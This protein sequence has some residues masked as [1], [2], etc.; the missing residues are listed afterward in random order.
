MQPT[1]HNHT[2][3]LGFPPRFYLVSGW[4]N[5]APLVFEEYAHALPV[6]VEAVLEALD[7][8]DDGPD[9][10]LLIDTGAG[11]VTD[12]T[13]DIAEA[14]ISRDEWE[15]KPAPDWAYEAIGACPEVAARDIRA[16]N[17]AWDAQ[18]DAVARGVYTR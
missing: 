6:T 9:R 15:R 12:A 16:D 11:T 4:H 17:A 10:I 7:Q 5:G 14:V 1:A 3:A 2:P 18:C 13:R 8:I